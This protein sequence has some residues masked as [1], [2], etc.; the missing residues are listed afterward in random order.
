MAGDGDARLMLYVA[1]EY[2][3]PRDFA[4]YVYLSQLTQAEGIELAALHHRASRPR[5]MGSLYWQLND[6]WPGASWSSIDFYGRWKPLQFH[7]RHFFAP[8]AVA[9]LRHDGKTEVS[10]ISDRTT[11]VAG[12]WRLSV[13]DFSGKPLR[14][15][16]HDIALAPLSANRVANLAD[17]ELLHGADPKRTTAAFEL[18]IEGTRVSRSIVYFA[19]AKD[20][21][22]R[23]PQLHTQWQADGDSY[24]LT[25]SA[26]QFARAV[27][28]DFGALDAEVSDNAFDL[29]PGETVR[30]RVQSSA[31]LDA[32]RDA[33]TLHSYIPN[34]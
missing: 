2:G 21:A 25:L 1:R 5:T 11:P 4:D 17:V 8:V 34:A 20:L 18:W 3:A 6:V 32:L 19:A 28:I 30:V 31:A 33:L 15:E 23:D 24:T 9:A 14:A 29:L 27:W 26:K 22:L 10:L 7:A 13:F 16:S 12:Q